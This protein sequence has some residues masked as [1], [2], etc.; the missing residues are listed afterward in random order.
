MFIVCQ[1]KKKRSKTRKIIDRMEESKKKVKDERMKHR[2]M[3]YIIG[4]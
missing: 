2:D 3:G 4:N 1:S